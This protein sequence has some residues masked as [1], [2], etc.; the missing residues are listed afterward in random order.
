MIVILLISIFPSFM[1]NQSETGADMLL[2]YKF[3]S[4]DNGDLMLDKPLTRA[5]VAVILA[6]LK[7][8]KSEAQYYAAPSTFVD[9]ASDQWYAP[10]IAYG[11]AYRL[12]GGYPDG[13]YHPEASVS[14]QEFAAFL[15]NAMGYNGNYDYANVV[16]FSKSK[17][18][19]VGATN[20]LFLRKNAFESM[21][22]AVNQPVKGSEVALGVMLG[23]LEAG[24]VSD[25]KPSNPESIASEMV[26]VSARAFEVRFKKAVQNPDKM[27]FELKNQMNKISF[28]TV[29]NQ[30]NTVVKLISSY[31]LT[32]D[33]Y[34]VIV[35]DQS[36]NEP[37]QY[38]PYYAVTEKEAVTRISFDSETLIR[39]SDYVGSVRYKVFNQYDEDITDTSLGRGLKFSVSTNKPE[40][41]VDPR[42]GVITVQ[43]GTAPQ[44][45]GILKDLNNVT[46]TITDPFS[47]FADSKVLKVSAT[48][49]GISQVV[50]NGVVDEN[51][52]YVDFIYSTSKQY[53]LD[54]SVVDTDGNLIKSKSILDAS[55]VGGQ[56][57]LMVY[58][59]NPALV[60]VSKGFHPK[61]DS[62]VA[63]KINFLSVPDGDVY[64]TFGAVAPFSTSGDNAAFFNI[65]LKK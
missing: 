53:Y 43:H 37:I 38:G 3:I 45:S 61:R 10:Y 8:V 31:S 22:Q 65:V 51:G 6:E 1:E 18:I 35:V 39:Y 25:V 19:E 14:T 46:I 44:K 13:S 42:T 9:V 23:K 26:A 34:E 54:I 60:S 15:M 7:G 28:R 24:L 48:M 29:W 41:I 55:N 58:T 64:V 12:L 36:N 47:G 63:Y 52:E 2:K 16:S 20:G 40:P 57:A 49:N 30:D 62:E 21:W 5:Q 56:E 4:G 11:Q 17:N 33:K 50:I 27:T 32:P 59:T